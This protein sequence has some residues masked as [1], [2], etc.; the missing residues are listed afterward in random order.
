M[1]KKAETSMLA[2]LNSHCS[3][4]VHCGKV[5]TSGPLSLS[6]SRLRCTVGYN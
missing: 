2:S 6:L 5:V 3:S 4:T 1:S